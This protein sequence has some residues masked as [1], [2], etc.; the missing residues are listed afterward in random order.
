MNNSAIYDA[1]TKVVS[2]A[3][4]KNKLK[5]FEKESVDVIREVEKDKCDKQIEIDDD[6]M[7]SSWR[8][9]RAKQLKRIKD[10]MREFMEN[11]HGQLDRVG[12]EA[13][14]IKLSTKTERIICHLTQDEFRMCQTIE[15]ALTKLAKK[16]IETKFVSIEATK[17]P[18]F[19]EKLAIRILPTIICIL[20]GKVEEIII[21]F[22][23]IGGMKLD[24]DMLE[25][26]LTSH[27]M[28]VSHLNDC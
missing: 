8:E 16:H 14:I 28:I 21:G 15:S 19:T 26:L 1:A 13:D 17:A 6:D 23:K 11:G 10:E 12:T 25:E 2:E 20:N 9:R 5:E 22:D 4:I 27:K 3:V 24:F 7:I 18:F